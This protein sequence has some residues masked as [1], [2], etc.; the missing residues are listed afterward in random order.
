ML[1]LGDDKLDIESKLEERDGKDHYLKEEIVQLK[2]QVNGGSQ[3]IKQLG[4]NLLERGKENEK[5]AEMVCF[6]KNRLITENCFHTT[7]SAQKL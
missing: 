6:F 1:K 5:L 2:D 4:L 7:F 3:A